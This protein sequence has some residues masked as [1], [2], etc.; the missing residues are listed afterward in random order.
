MK[1]ID[2]RNGILTTANGATCGGVAGVPMIR[3]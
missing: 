3:R 1:G 2:A